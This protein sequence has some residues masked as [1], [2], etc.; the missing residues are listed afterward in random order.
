MRESRARPDSTGTGRA[1]AFSGDVDFRLTVARASIRRGAS[2]PRL[3]FSQIYFI[4]AL[5]LSMIACGVA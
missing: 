4:I 2:S 1:L 3:I 5:T